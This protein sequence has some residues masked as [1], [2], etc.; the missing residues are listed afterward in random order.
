MKLRRVLPGL[1]LIYPLAACQDDTN[2]IEDEVFAAAEERKLSGEFCEQVFTIEHM[3]ETSDGV[4]LRVTER[5]SPASVLRLPRRAVLMMPGTLVTGDMYDIEVESGVDF[6]ALDRAA[7]EGYFAYAVTYEG[8]PGSELPAH[9]GT[10]TADRVLEH[11]GEVVEWIRGERHVT[12]VDLFG[13]SFGSS[14]AT[15]LG[16]TQS[17]INRHHIGRIVLQ[18]LVYKEVTPLF[19]QVFFSPEV[20]AALENAP[21]GYILTAPEMYGLILLGADPEAAQWGFENF[22][23]VYATGPTL[24]GFDLPLFEGTNGRA[25]ALQFW[26]TIDPITPIEDA[27]NF[28]D[29]YGGPS[30]LI[31][32]PE[33]GHAP[34]IGDEVTREIFWS[35]SL[36][37][38]D[39]NPWTFYIG[40]EP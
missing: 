11:M 27:E 23:D 29:E 39:Y 22:P 2:A 32:I 30:D 33:A 35:E 8:Y 21:N 26:G 38:L 36:E 9:G 15:A 28:Q 17:P 10:V 37:F 40:C 1:L 3:F 14:L 12:R 34:Y 16:G 6:S 5:L 19:E 4:E 31:V 7:R 24:E 20:Q 25:P 13:A 18:A